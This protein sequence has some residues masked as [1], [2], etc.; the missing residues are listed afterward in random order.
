MRVDC[1]LCGRSFHPSSISAHIYQFHTEN[2]PLRIDPVDE[3]EKPIQE[4]V[5]EGRSRRK[6]AEKAINLLQNITTE[7]ND[8]NEQL[9]VPKIMYRRP[10]N[11]NRS[12][13]TA[14]LIKNLK[15][16]LKTNGSLN[17]KFKNCMYICSDLEA[18]KK[19][20]VVCPI[21][22]EDDYTCRVCLFTSKEEEIIKEHVYNEHVQKP[23]DTVLKVK[24]EEDEE[25]EDEDEEEIPV[26]EEEKLVPI[27]HT[28]DSSPHKSKK[29]MWK[30]SKCHFLS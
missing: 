23:R 19:H 13:L 7:E 14:S 1:E 22:E 3:I 20:L 27:L 18:M 16:E 26:E 29:S 6:A 15:K 2:K 4:I 5:T 8:T 21:R 11:P 28:A 9:F 30:T 17:C 25:D 12:V 10:D 24:E